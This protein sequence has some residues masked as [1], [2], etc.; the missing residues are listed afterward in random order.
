MALAPSA[1]DVHSMLK[2]GL[3]PWKQERVMDDGDEGSRLDVELPTH[4][5]GAHGAPGGGRWKT[6]NDVLA[7]NA[8]RLGSRRA[9]RGWTVKVTAVDDDGEENLLTAASETGAR[10]TALRDYQQAAVEAGNPEHSVF[11]SHFVSGAIE[12]GCGLGKTFVA[13][14]LLRRVRKASGGVPCVV[15]TQH[16][17]SVDQWIE[18]LT[19]RVGMLDAMSLNEARSQWS[20]DHPKVPGVLVLTY[21]ALV[22]AL[23]ALD[24][25]LTRAE[26]HD[27]EAVDVRDHRL[28]W[29]LLCVPFGALVLD[30]MHM[31]VADHW[32]G[33][34]RLRARVVYG[35]SGSLVRE[36]ER[37][38]RMQRVVGP[39]IFRH[40][41]ARTVAYEVVR[42]P[43]APEVASALANAKARSAHERAARALNPCKMAALRTLLHRHRHERVI[44]FC[45]SRRGA[46]LLVSHALPTILSPSS[47]SSSSSSSSNSPPVLLLHGSTPDEERAE[48][49]RTFQS[50]TTGGVLVSTRVCDAAVDF[51]ENCVVVQLLVASG[52]RQQEMQRCGRG[53]RGSGLTGSRMV[54]LVNVGTEEEDYVQRRV[55]YVCQNFPGST[56]EEVDWSHESFVSAT[57]APPLDEPFARAFRALTQLRVR[58]TA[59]SS[60]KVPKARRH[61]PAL[62]VARGPYGQR[63]QC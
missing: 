43:L 31:A 23:R 30:E 56:V 15:V 20:L 32:V 21:S 35:L 6:G 29:W 4:G 14:E 58:T 37:L 27:P 36:D 2:T 48:T 34:T 47:F 51:P 59:A 62:R 1:H 16:T 17:I 12:M 3:R 54:H 24:D 46:E 11:H 61:R 39:V 18:H 13:G 42:V 9:P 40:C 45:D 41:D 10:A 25:H 33:A 19:H 49:L 50:Q 55:D 26:R 63:R 57:E 28:I 8:R 7:H 5:T 60:G 22:A 53:S 38:G 52:G 44:L